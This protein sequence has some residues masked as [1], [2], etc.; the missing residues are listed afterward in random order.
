M[1]VRQKTIKKEA[2]KSPKEKKEE[3]R[4]KKAAKQ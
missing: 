4:L 2:L 3:K 1:N